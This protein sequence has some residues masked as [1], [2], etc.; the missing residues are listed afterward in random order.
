MSLEQAKGRRWLPPKTLMVLP[1]ARLMPRTL[2]P[3]REVDFVTSRTDERRGMESSKGAPSL[4]EPETARPILGPIP[5]PPYGATM[6]A[7]SAHGISGGHQGR[8]GRMSSG[9]SSCSTGIPHPINCGFILPR[10][11]WYSLPD[12]NCVKAFRGRIR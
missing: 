1:L 3:K 9:A 10:L 5:Y 7:S 6:R 4:G 11:T 2:G 8:I 12:P